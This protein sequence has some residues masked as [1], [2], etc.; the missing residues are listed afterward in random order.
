MINYDRT[1][2]VLAVVM[3]FV[4]V[5]EKWT[6]IWDITQSASLLLSRRMFQFEFEFQSSPAFSLAASLFSSLLFSLFF[7]RFALASPKNAQER[8]QQSA[9]NNDDVKPREM[10]AEETLLDSPRTPR[11]T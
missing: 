9:S 1:N 10:N 6:V 8:N 3:S 4:S 7:H 5:V 11:R 2:A